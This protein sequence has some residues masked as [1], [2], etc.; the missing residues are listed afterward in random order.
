MQSPKHSRILNLI[1]TAFL[2]FY[3]LMSFTIL[4]DDSTAVEKHGLLTVSGNRILGQHGNPVVLRGMSLFWSQWI[5]K[6]YNYDCIKWLRDN[7][8]CTVV[9]AAMG[10]ESGGYLSNPAVEKARIKAVI[11]ACID[12]GIYVI[13]DWHDHNAQDHQEQA[14]AFF[15]EIAEEYGE[16]PNLIYEIFN[17]PLLQVSWSDVIKPYANA[18]VGAIRAID[19]DNLIVVGTPTWSQDV[20]IATASPLIQTNIAYSLHF[21]A[22]THKLFLRKKAMTALNRGYALFVSE[23]GTCESNGSGVMDVVEVE[24]WM[25][26]MEYHQISWCNWSLADKDETSAALKPGASQTGGWTE[27]QISESGL[28]I[29]DYIINGNT[30]QINAIAVRPKK[31]KGFELN[32]NYPNPFNMSTRLSFNLPY[33]AEVRLHIFDLNGK[34]VSTLQNSYLPAGYYSYIWNADTDAGTKAS[35]GVYLLRVAVLAEGEVT[36]DLKKMVLLK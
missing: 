8:K 32:Q 31:P 22:A 27:D 30:G 10:V 5:G 29:R 7:W 21:Y 23:F 12:L 25:N 1:F 26:F 14:I 16:Y 35:C 4:A 17:E 13:V 6:Y 18:V 20:D 3:Y 24:T 2:A 15:E 33:S 34:L 28:L 36:T 19:E 11:D 9:R